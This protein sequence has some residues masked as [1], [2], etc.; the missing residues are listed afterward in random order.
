MGSM[1]VVI[2]DDEP[3][4]Q[5]VLKKYLANIHGVTLVGAFQD[6]DTAYNFILK[7]PVDLVISDIGM[8]SENGLAFAKR[9]LDVK[10]QLNLVFLTAYVQYALEAFGVQAFDYIVKP[11]TK[12]RLEQ[13]ITRLQTKLQPQVPAPA[14]LRVYCL[15][16][17]DVISQSGQRVHWISSKSEEVFAYLLLNL[18]RAVSRDRL[19]ED[20]F[21]DM[22]LQKAAIY[23]NT[24]VYQLRKALKQ[25]GCT[26]IVIS[27][28]DSYYIDPTNVYIDFIDF[29]KT[30]QQ[31]T[32]S[33]VFKIQ[34]A[35]EG[36]LLYKGDLLE[37][38]AYIWSYPQRERL[39][40]EYRKLAMKLV[41]HLLKI[42]HSSEAL[43]IL[44][45]VIDRDPL[46][47]DANFLFMKALAMDC[48]WPL[49]EQYY[50]EQKAK[51]LEEIGPEP[52][53]RLTR[54]YQELVNTNKS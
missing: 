19:I 1:R 8:P 49:L 23:L 4:M 13:T 38:K 44:S 42:K 29:E 45:K 47:E 6:T 7:E 14:R 15:G 30:V 5:L 50:N 28:G 32:S 34:A 37:Q 52:S 11:V 36:E 46:D 16:G 3:A 51:Y 48:N 43:P 22:S 33:A 20:I 41:Q 40:A 9:L 12:Q 2:I 24:A 35:L 21:Q 53:E 17:L 26:D 18:G 27:S 10:P 31:L 25:H 39:Y 54:F